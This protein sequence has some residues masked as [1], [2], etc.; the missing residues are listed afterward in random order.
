MF[1]PMWAQP[2]CRNIEVTTRSQAKSAGTRP[3]LLHEQLERTP[4]E[5]LLVQEHQHVQHDQGDRDD[6]PGAGRND[7]PQ[8][9]HRAEYTWLADGAAAGRRRRPT[10]CM[11]CQNCGTEI[12]DKAIVCF[13]CGQATVAAVR[14]PAPPPSRLRGLVSLIALVLL[15]LAA[16]FLGQAGTID[17]PPA[18]ALRRDRRSR[19]RCWRGG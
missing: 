14:K 1:P 18:V 10:P 15:A 7:V 3:Q 6:R 4:A 2:P 19:S 12:A 9:N 13:R 11:V 5:R 16:L 17:V 8:G